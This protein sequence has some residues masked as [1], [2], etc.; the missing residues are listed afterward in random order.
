MG[1]QQILHPKI[2]HCRGG[3]PALPKR[4]DGP[5]SFINALPSKVQISATSEWIIHVID[6]KK[7]NVSFSFTRERQ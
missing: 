1:I 3:C 6:G 4:K 5:D 7:K 2:A